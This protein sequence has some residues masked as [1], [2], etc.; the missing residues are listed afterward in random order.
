MRR[1]QIVLVAYPGVQSLDVS[2]PTHKIIAQVNQSDLAL[3][4][5]RGWF[6]DDAPCLNQAADAVE[7]GTGGRH[8][9]PNPFRHSR[10]AHLSL[11]ARIALFSR[12]LR[13]AR[14]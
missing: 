6:V 3:I 9:G 7:Q 4:R 13:P 14:P 5:E 2:G 1:R 12:T 8:D 11:F 10:F